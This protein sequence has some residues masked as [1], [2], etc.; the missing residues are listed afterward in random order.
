MELDSGISSWLTCPI[1]PDLNT[2]SCPDYCAGT[3][4][5]GDTSRYVC[6]DARLG[7]VTV[8]T[9]LPLSGIAG[10]DSTYRRFG[11]LCPGEFLASWTD[12]TTGAYMYPPYDGYQ[13]TTTGQEA[14]F[15][16][17]IPVGTFLD[18]FGSEYGRFMSPAGL[19]YSQRSLPPTNLDAA[20]GSKYPY[21]YQVYMVSRSLHVQ[22]GLI[23]SWFEQQGLGVQF[24]VPDT[25]LQLVD[26]GYLSR[27]NLTADPNW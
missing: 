18:R 23:A 19:S 9:G 13:L 24:L 14:M 8:P 2:T 1:Q 25:V 16:L 10:S 5:T 7:P 17:T 21:N 4:S 11:G 3:N 12:P 6:G 20:P 27:V 15:N 22:G 26:T